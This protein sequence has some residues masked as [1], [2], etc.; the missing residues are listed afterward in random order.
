MKWTRRP[1]GETRIKRVFLLWPWELDGET[2]WLEFAY[3][4]QKYCY[5]GDGY[6]AWCD[7]H[8]ADPSERLERPTSRHRWIDS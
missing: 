3:I 1:E 7:Q 8:W 2:R 5:Q 4:E 6:Y